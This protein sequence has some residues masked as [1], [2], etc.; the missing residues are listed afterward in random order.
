MGCRVEPQ[1][2]LC[3]KKL[4]VGPSSA[5]FVDSILPRLEWAGEAKIPVFVIQT[6]KKFAKKISVH[7]LQQ[8][9]YFFHLIPINFSRLAKL[10]DDGSSSHQATGFVCV[11]VRSDHELLVTWKTNFQTLRCTVEIM[12][13]AKRKKYD[14]SYY[15][16]I[17]TKF[18]C[19]HGDIGADIASILQILWFPSIVTANE[20]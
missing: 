12:A 11:S 4:D 14:L 3:C 15:G 13:I 10:A 8:S 2:G 18:L 16:V 7:L 6:F 20:S 1:F 19:L 9:T 17:F 5:V